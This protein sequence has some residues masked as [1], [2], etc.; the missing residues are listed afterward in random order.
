VVNAPVFHA[1]PSLE[2]S[3]P[4]SIMVELVYTYSNVAAF[5]LSPL[6]LFDPTAPSLFTQLM[7]CYKGLCPFP[8]QGAVSFFLLSTNWAVPFNVPASA[9]SLPFFFPLFL[10]FL[11]KSAPF[12]IPYRGPTWPARFPLS[13]SHSVKRQQF[14]WN[15]CFKADITWFLILY[16]CLIIFA[17]A[18]KKLVE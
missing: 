9:C 11:S 15:R 4:S 8:V 12:T 1:P 13:F 18:W 14:Q 2:I 10:C 5:F 17:P 6:P 7:C 3:F 16:F